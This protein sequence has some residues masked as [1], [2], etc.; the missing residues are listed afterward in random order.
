MT[1]E[2]ADPT[3]ERSGK[4]AAGT[5]GCPPSC[6][7]H[8]FREYNYLQLSPD[9]RGLVKL[10]PVALLRFDGNYSAA[11]STTSRET[12]VGKRTLIHKTTR[13]PASRPQ[14]LEVQPYDCLSQGPLYIIVYARR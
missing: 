13:S 12:K 14:G 8:I 6:L 3:V 1:R 7:P 10:S 4:V 11:T 5:I 9:A 2:W